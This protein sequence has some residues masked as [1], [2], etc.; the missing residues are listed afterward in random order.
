MK[1]TAE[2][3]AD[4]PVRMSAQ[5]R[6][7]IIAL[8]RP[9]GLK[10]SVLRTLADKDVRAPQKLWQSSKDLIQPFGQL[11]REI[12]RWIHAANGCGNIPLLVDNY[13]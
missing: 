8:G 10:V 4:I 9:D 1:V 6:T 11:F 2:W 13:H 3:S 7:I 12:S 5:A